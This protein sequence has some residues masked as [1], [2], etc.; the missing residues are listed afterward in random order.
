M[1][2]QIYS[3]GASKGNPGVSSVAFIIFSEDQVKL[4]EHA[5]II[6]VRTN[7]Q[8]E[9]E[10]L[11]SALECATKL[12]SQEI[13]CYLDSELLVKQINGDFQVKNIK[14]RQYWRRVQ[15][16]KQGF[17]QI[18]FIH[19]PRAESHIQQVDK[20]ANQVLAHAEKD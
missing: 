7:N 3:D 9:Y 15:E 18:T 5:K 6:G 11:I 2:L 1:K 8:A 12:A 17:H 14:L 13:W 20:L 16:L 19:V 4:C 10:A